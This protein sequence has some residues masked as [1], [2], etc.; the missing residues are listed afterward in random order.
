MKIVI[1]DMSEEQE[2][3]LND[4]ISSMSD[5]DCK[6]IETCPVL[7]LSFPGLHIDT[8]RKK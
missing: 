7:E 8:L 1:F 5:A 3:M 6:V 2:H 4:F